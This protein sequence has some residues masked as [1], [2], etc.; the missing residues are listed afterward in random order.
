MGVNVTELEEEYPPGVG[1]PSGRGWRSLSPGVRLV[2][3]TTRLW[4][5]P[6]WSVDELLSPLVELHDVLPELEHDSNRAIPSLSGAASGR[7]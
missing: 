4:V 2:E 7:G 3:A 5:S 6:V 1:N